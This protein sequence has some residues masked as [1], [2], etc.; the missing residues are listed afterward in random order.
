MVVFMI[1]GKSEPLYEAD[2]GAVS[3]DLSYLHQF[4]LHSSLDML[5]TV[6]WSNS[7]TYLKNIDRFNSLQVSA[8]ITPGGMT[9]LLLHNG[10]NE[11][12]IK[13]FFTDMNEVY[14]K[15]LMN[16]FAIYDAP[17]ISPQFDIQVGN[18]AKRHFN[19]S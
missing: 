12:I 13:A 3:D 18:I 2:I 5:S 4:I 15:Y 1:V 9:F 11:D 10:K 17:I 8:Y 7:S 16:P 19:E 14:V 6:L